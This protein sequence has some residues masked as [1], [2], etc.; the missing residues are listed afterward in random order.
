MFYTVSCIFINAC[1]YVYFNA[2]YILIGIFKCALKITSPSQFGLDCVSLGV[3][4]RFVLNVRLNNNII[5]NNIEYYTSLCH[6]LPSHPHDFPYVGTHVL[7]Q[8]SLF[9]AC[10]YCRCWFSFHYSC[11]PERIYI[12][13]RARET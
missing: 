2:L 13:E 7:K 5:N 9:H 12:Y 6:T 11:L 10:N 1:V 8:T 3:P 4:F